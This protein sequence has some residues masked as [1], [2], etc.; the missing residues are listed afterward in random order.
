MIIPTWAPMAGRIVIAL[1]LVAAG[2]TLN[3][4]KLGSELEQERTTH[5]KAQRDSE[6][7]AKLASENYRLKEGEW[8]Q[9]VKGSQDALIAQYQ[10]SSRVILGLTADRDRLRRDIAGFAAGPRDAA[11]DTITSCRRDAATLGDVLADALQ[12]EEDVTAAAEQH[13][14]STRALLAAWPE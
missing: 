3:G 14:A 13:A 12:R 6:A 5:A 7:A 9:K 8:Q 11:T 1:A 4:W 2:W 10:A